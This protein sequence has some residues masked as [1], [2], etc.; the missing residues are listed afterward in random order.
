MPFRIF[1]LILFSFLRRTLY[2]TW[3]NHHKQLQVTI[4]IFNKKRLWM[5]LASPTQRTHHHETLW[6]FYQE[7][8]LMNFSTIVRGITLVLLWFRI[9]VK[10]INKLVFTITHICSIYQ[11]SMHHR[12]AYPEPCQTSKMKH[13]KFS[14][15]L[16]S[17]NALF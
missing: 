15:K 7:S 11:V 16:F 12:E 9:I 4:M 13:L 5:F 14:L 3:K 17:Q 1:L 8:L 2:N 6:I 10:T